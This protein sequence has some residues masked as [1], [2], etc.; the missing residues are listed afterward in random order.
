MVHPLCGRTTFRSAFTPGRGRG[1]PQVLEPPGGS[2]AGD[3]ERVGAG[4]DRD[5]ER[6]PFKG[7]RPLHLVGGGVLG[8]DRLQQVVVATP[9]QAVAGRPHLGQPGEQREAVV[10]PEAEEV[11]EFELRARLIHVPGDG[12]TFKNERR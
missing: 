9:A 4:E 11:A 5:L 3:V 7:D 8:Q 1:D 10:I 12:V 6:G 2:R